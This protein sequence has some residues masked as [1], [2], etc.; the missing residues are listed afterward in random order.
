MLKLAK[1]EFGDAYTDDIGLESLRSRIGKQDEAL[2]IL[3]AHEDVCETLDKKDRPAVEKAVSEYKKE[4]SAAVTTIQALAKTI[5]ERKKKEA[6]DAAAAEALAAKGR[7]R[8]RGGRAGAKAKAKAAAAAVA[9]ALPRV[10][11]ERVEFVGELTE[12]LIETFLPHGARI[13][14]DPLDSSWRVTYKGYRITRA[15]TK[16][17]PDGA[18]KWLI[19]YSWTLAWELGFVSEFPFELP[20]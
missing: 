16:Y 10:Y 20:E 2:A 14:Q 12:Q 9:A 1:H 6:D 8:G 18:A 5:G 15:W 3:L 13:G 17:G 19:R 11:P 4:K 7:G